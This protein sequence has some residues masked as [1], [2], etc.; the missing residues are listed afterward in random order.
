MTGWKNS[1][2]IP[3]NNF[4]QPREARPHSGLP[5]LEKLAFSHRTSFGFKKKCFKTYFA[6]FKRSL[7][8]ASVYPKPVMGAENKLKKKIFF[9]GK[10]NFIQALWSWGTGNSC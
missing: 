4:T 5:G 9:A 10:S 1:K 2:K 7:P 6:I 8:K 3:S